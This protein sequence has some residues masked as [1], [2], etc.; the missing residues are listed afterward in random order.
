MLIIG[1]KVYR[2]ENGI[3]LRTGERL[4]DWFQIEDDIDS[5]QLKQDENLL[6]A[7]DQVKGKIVVYDMDT[8]K[9]IS[10]YSFES[11]L[12]QVYKGKIYY[13]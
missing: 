5:Y 10:E 8:S 13:R 9:Q 4:E 12:W 3:Y 11:L 2:K 1:A 7:Q 6:I